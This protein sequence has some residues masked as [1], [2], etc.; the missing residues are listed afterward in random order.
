MSF[1]VYQDTNFKLYQGDCINFMRSRPDGVFDMIF[2]DP[3]Y[4]L[5][6]GG[7]SVASG[8][9]TSVNKGQWDAS[10][11]FV[12]DAA[13][14]DAWINECRRVLKPNGTIW[15]TGT[16][17]SIYQCGYSLQKAGYHLLN[18]ISWYKANAS[19]NLSCRC[20]TASH[21]TI[22]WAKKDKKAKHY[23]DYAAMKMG[24]W[25]KD[26]MKKEKM[27]MRSVWS[28]PTTP[29]V[30]KGFGKHPTQ[31]P[32]ELLRRIIL[33][34]TGPEAVIFDP[35]LGSG[36]TGVATILAGGGRQFVG[37]DTEKS[38]INLTIQRYENTK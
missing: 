9:R 14:H 22:L 35:F 18:D 28:I 27:Q 13:F 16:Y 6:N 34:S 15:I 29:K 4:F 23:F 32:L 30:E 26:K 11:G 37:C 1:P 38:F 24:Q 25:P 21:E 12:V 20:F 17:H 2:A 31:K 36:S 10:R 8:R 33:A 5:S 7:C 19:P 3:P